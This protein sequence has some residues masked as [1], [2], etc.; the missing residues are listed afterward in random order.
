MSAMLCVTVTAQAATITVNNPTDGSVG[1]ACTLRD[2]VEAVNT[3]AAVNGC[4]AGDG[5]SDTIV[6][7]AAVFNV[8][9]TIP[10]SPEIDITRSLTINGLLDG[11]GGPLIT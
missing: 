1:G 3:A 2:A 6:F 10:V 8:A 7:D 11:N 5:S 9:T 4:V